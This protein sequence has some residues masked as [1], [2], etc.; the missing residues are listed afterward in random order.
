MFVCVRACTHSC[1]AA[2]W[3]PCHGLSTPPASCACAACNTECGPKATS[4]HR[5]FAGDGSGSCAAA[6]AAHAS[7]RL[8]SRCAAHATHVRSRCATHARSARAGCR[9]AWCMRGCTC[10][11]LCTCVG[12]GVGAGARTWAHTPG[13]CQDSAAVLREHCWHAWRAWSTWCAWFTWRAW[14]TWCAEPWGLMRQGTPTSSQS[15]VL[16]GVGEPDS[17]QPAL[18]ERRL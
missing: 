17:V 9:P 18:G 13:G 16:A 4:V 12:V 10:A 5:A 11:P 1:A 7:V 15:A 6:A 3:L 2:R 14:F 8:R